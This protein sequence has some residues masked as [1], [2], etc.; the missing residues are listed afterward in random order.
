MIDESRPALSVDAGTGL[1]LD[2][3]SLLFAAEYTV[4]MTINF[5]SVAEGEQAKLLDFSNLT[6]DAGIYVAGGATG[7][8]ISFFG[9]GAAA[10]D[11]HHQRLALPAGD[12]H[13]Q[14]I[15]GR[16]AQ[17]RE[18]GV[19]RLAVGALRGTPSSRQ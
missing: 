16:R 15:L 6:S 17:A 18:I 8:A 2:V 3:G 10:G 13:R 7:P 19:L 14:R 12:V 1:R 5:G 9:D 11:D 4:V